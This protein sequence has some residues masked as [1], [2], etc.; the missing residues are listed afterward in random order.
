MLRC[1]KTATGGPGSAKLQKRVLEML[2][3][4]EEVALGPPLQ[5][6]FIQA[7]GVTALLDIVVDGWP[8]GSN[9]L[10]HSTSLTPWWSCLW[11]WM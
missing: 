3:L 5:P 9:L 4:Q 7:G 8:D 10:S 6:A 2:R 11:S 1:L